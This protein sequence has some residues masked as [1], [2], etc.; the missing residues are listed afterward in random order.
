MSFP[1][2]HIAI[3]C[4]DLAAGEA[5]LS[6]RLGAAPDGGGAHPLMGTHNRLWRLGPADYLEL[7][8][9]DPA[10]PAPSRA[11]WFGL[12]GF[13]G[14]PQVAGWVVQAPDTTPAPPGSRW[15]TA[16]RGAL[17]W[18]ITIADSGVT[19]AGG[20]APALIDWQGAPHPA[21]RLPDRG[22]R[23]VRLT[24][25]H[26]DAPATEA[27][28]PDAGQPDATQPEATQPDAGPA[29]ARPAEA[30]VF[31]ARPAG[32][33]Q[34]DSLSADTGALIALTRADARITWRRG[35]CAMTVTIATPAGEV[36]L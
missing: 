3:A 35:P 5:W 34:S 9:I 8:A 2:D 4:T 33:A 20:T 25:S 14:P 12:D 13:S 31:D 15:E 7:I 6:A 11:R 23:L 32:A 21:T 29:T 17:S 30:P 26:P 36:T 18:R 1:L 22:L 28:Q 19:A 10:A 16:S 27:A 24:L